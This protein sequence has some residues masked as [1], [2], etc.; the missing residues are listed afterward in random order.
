MP[1]RSHRFAKCNHLGRGSICHR[2][3]QADQLDAKIATHPRDK[4]A[5]AWANEAA[6]LRG[7]AGKKPPVAPVGTQP[8]VGYVPYEDNKY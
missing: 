3:G 5:Q 8:S 1:A 6:R 2:C 4:D 7:T